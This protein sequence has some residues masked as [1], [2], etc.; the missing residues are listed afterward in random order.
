MKRKIL[1]TGGSGFI[2]SN[3]KK[4]LTNLEYEVL[5]VGRGEKEDFKIDLISPELKNII[6]DFSPDIVCH[7]ASGSNIT[8]ANENKEKEFKDTVIATNNLIK[9][10][11][12][13]TVK[14]LYLSSQAVYG[15]PDFLPMS[16]NH[17]KK[18]N[19][20]YGENKLKVENIITESK[21]NYLIFRVSSVYGRD[22][23]PEKSGVIAKF[24]HKL[25]NNQFPVVYNSYDLFSDF[26]YVKDLACAV[27][28]ALQSDLFKN[29]VFNLGFGKPASLK[30]I[31]K[32]LYKYFPDAPKPELQLNPLYFD[33]NYK[34]LYLDIT[35]IQSELKWKCKYNLED[36]LSE[37]LG[38]VKHIERV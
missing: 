9:Q 22:Q 21:L 29:E 36:G 33:G 20:V 5:S 13:K 38:N 31:L 26:I 28:A 32:I 2:G 19:T 3:L 1:I 11:E 16:E 30:K 7:F 17:P 8:R 34:G 27:V 23:N 14:F 35:K 6:E 24:L 18:P 37:M 4:S 12:G 25:R 15:L 10:L